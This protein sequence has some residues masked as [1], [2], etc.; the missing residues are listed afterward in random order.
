MAVLS[1]HGGVDEIGGN[2]I[3]LEQ[4]SGR[5][6]LD[7]GT[8][9][10]CQGRFFHEYLNPRKLNGMGDWLRMGMAPDIAGVY[11]QDLRAKAGLPEE[12]R[13]IDAIVLSHAHMDH[14]GLFPLVR[15]DVPLFMSEGSRLILQALES[16]GAAGNSDYL[17]FFEEFRVR[18]NKKGGFSKTD[19]SDAPSVPRPVVTD[20]EGDAGGFRIFG[21]GVDHSL[22][23]ARGY[24]IETEAGSVAYTGDF[25]FHGR[26]GTRSDR[27]AQ[28][29]GGVD[30]LIT[31]GTNMG[32]ER[33]ADR[34]HDQP[35]PMSEPRVREHLTEAVAKSDGFTAVN[36]PVRDLDR[37]LSF[38][39]AAKANS[40]RL[41]LSTKQAVLL[42]GFSKAG[43]DVPSLEDPAIGIYIA[44]R[45]WGIRSDP[46]LSQELPQLAQ[47]EYRDFERP[48]L[49]HPHAA[50]AE[51][52]HK[53]PSA[54]LVYVDLFN[55][56]ELIDIDPSGGTYIYSKTEPFN[57][58]MDIDVGRLDNWLEHF[59]LK[60]VKA[61]ASGHAA[62]KELTHM[63]DAA[64]P[65]RIVP[66]HTMNV[67]GFE[68]AFGDRVT[69]VRAGQQVDL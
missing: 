61:H 66:V 37:I 4:K 7:F 33:E 10:G 12:E 42:D 57:D 58:E 26:D 64:K 19:R 18:E 16:T 51:D 31:E 21:Q 36:Y 62:P 49:D 13:G 29:I 40:R 43:W 53:E 34:I 59:G 24:I 11:R 25:R 27:F 17:N 46:R 9:F 48:L 32:T 39:E 14:V 22:P 47:G 50:T 65:K 23:G 6:L 28:R 45:G 60:K 8:S 63:I 52:V 54:F 1:V 2:R 55:M 38:W 44:R 41:L 20:D 56:T 35:E 67:K 30:V 3:L 68:Q 15:P 5:I 69:R